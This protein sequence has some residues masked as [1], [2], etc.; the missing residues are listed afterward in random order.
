MGP[1]FVLDTGGETLDTP[2]VSKKIHS[3]RSALHQLYIIFYVLHNL[4]NACLPVWNAQQDTEKRTPLHAAAYLGDTEIIELLILSGKTTV[5]VF[6]VQV[7]QIKVVLSKL[8]S[9]NYRKIIY[10]GKGEG[11]K[12]SDDQH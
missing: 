2:A 11:K 8:Q 1:K 7:F 6:Q 9:M 5:N 3:W 12:K 4:Q 10:D